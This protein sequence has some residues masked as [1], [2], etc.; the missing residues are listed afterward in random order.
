MSFL[1]KLGLG[2]LKGIKVAAG[3]A[4]YVLAQLPA[5]T[6]VRAFDVMA[7]ICKVVVNAE[8][9]VG[10]ISDPNAKTG[11]Q[12]L[13]AATPVVLQ[14]LKQSEFLA[15]KQI[16]NEDLLMEAAREY[17]DATAKLLNSLKPLE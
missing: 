7:E 3:Y 11:P 4:P 1:K 14:L 13:E 16:Y 2:I 5:G 12:K 8:V 17:A 6:G 9:M 10:A 15:G